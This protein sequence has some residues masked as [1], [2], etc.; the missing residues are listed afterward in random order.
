MKSRR[1]AH[2]LLVLLVA[3]GL[4][5][6]ATS[7]A[8]GPE[9]AAQGAGQRARPKICLALSGG[10]AR[11]AA[12]IGVLKVLEELRVPVDCIAGTS[13]GALVGGAYAA[14]M[15]IDEMDGITRSITTELLF[16]EKPPREE[17][18]MRRKADDYD[19]YIG[20]EIAMQGAHPHLPKG[21]VSGVQLETVLRRLSKVQGTYR[22]DDLPI[23]YRA[24]ATNLVTGK[25]VVFEQGELANVMRASMAVPGAVAPA[26]FGGMMF[27]D[28]M[29]TQNLPVETARAMGADV[30][31]AVDVGTPL[32]T[33]EQ[34][35][36]VLGVTAQM[37]SILTQQNVEASLAS[38]QP[39]D[40]LIT[41]QLG[42]HSTG[43]FDKLAEIAPLGEAAT[44][45][46][47][48]RLARLA[49]PAA[50]YAELRMR[51]Q[52]RVEPD[53][54]PVDE[55]RFTDLKMV[56]PTTVLAAMDTKAGR[57]IDQ[58]ALDRDM[59]RI[60]GMGYFEHVNY[61]FVEEPG[62]RVL[63]VDA[64]E[65]TWG[66]D[67]VR[68]GLGLASDLKGDAYFNLIGSYRKSWLNSLGAEWR[69]T[70]QVGR[71]TAF[72]SEFYQPLRPEGR[73][74]VAPNVILE[75]RAT[76]VYQGSQ[77]VATFKT[78]STLAG[79]DVGTLFG[80]Y[81]EARVGLR[82]GSIH[83]TLDTGPAAL[84]P[85][86]G[87]VA[88]GAA[89]ARVLFDRLDSVDFP[90]V[91]WRA[92]ARAFHS[93]TALGAGV[94][95]TKWDF[96]GAVAHSFGEHTFYAGWKFGGKLGHEPLPR[97][98]L[99]Q[100][101]GFLQQSGYA[102]GQLIGENLSFGRLLYYHRILK[103]SFLEG[104]YGG[105]SL[106][107]GR[108]GHP[109]VPGAPTGT[110]RSMALFVGA[111]TPLGPAYFGYGRSQDGNSNWYVF[112]GRPY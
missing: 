74:F 31:I 23:P 5:L 73:F 41:P 90:R 108:V 19:I 52:V 25:P 12:H 30:V 6:P 2:A 48:D 68:F 28:G 39:Q 89:T 93:N 91:G 103:G 102:P 18:S 26:E 21:L 99:F 88:Q 11:G 10:G 32:L 86:A 110:L 71:T 47:A 16:K 63:V 58:Q 82:W 34:L 69:S 20:P 66:Q 50:E 105:A 17:R 97:Y 56:N 60:Y 79:F 51:Q 94:D 36:G 75:R 70:L 22:F 40:I 76:D 81:G 111:D 104:A 45:K 37:V 7:P 112:L 9:P 15:S 55:I 4:G 44:R 29:L 53:L 46:V 61:S 84:E 92:G 24:V 101:G 49:L 67:T 77:R 96:D 109:L 54:R 95:Y 57:P 78:T 13:M 43:D 42:D 62:R 87:S 1:S 83:P 3:A 33:R 64:V 65:K 85:P 72:N 59:R 80:R 35:S 38:L 98:D 8:A 27:A 14:G 100:W 106:E 107:V